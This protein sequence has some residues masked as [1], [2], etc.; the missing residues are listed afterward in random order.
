MNIR[1]RMH[2]LRHI[3]MHKLRHIHFR[4]HIHFRTRKLGRLRGGHA[5]S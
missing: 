4:M 1:F 5:R 2:K 3:R